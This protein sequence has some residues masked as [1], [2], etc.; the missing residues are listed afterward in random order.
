MDMDKARNKI[1]TKLVS[2]GMSQSDAEQYVKD[3]E[4]RVRTGAVNPFTEG[5]EFLDKFD[6][7]QEYLEELLYN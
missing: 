1:V 5:E 3:F 6:L 2:D 7:E 4:N